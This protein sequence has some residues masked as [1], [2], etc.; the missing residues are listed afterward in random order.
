MT[1]WASEAINHGALQS[2][3][4]L[5]RLLAYLKP[6][7]PKSIVEIGC[8][9]GGT[10]YAWMQFIP[11]VI[12]IDLPMAEYCS[13]KPLHSYGAEVILGNSHDEKTKQQLLDYLNGERVDILFI[14]GDHSYEGVKQDFEMYRDVVQDNGLVIFHDI[15]GN[16]ILCKGVCKFWCELKEQYS[17]IEFC[18]PKSWA[19]I[20]VLN[21]G[22]RT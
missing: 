9:A 14:D 17:Y 6:L 11:K 4:E 8:D 13:G 2:Y 7:E 19:G 3:Y 18:E 21:V 15:G 5:E 1:S 16:E 12:G 10:L 20:G 22:E